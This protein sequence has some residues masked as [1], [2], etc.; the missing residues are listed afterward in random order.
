[1]RIL[2]TGAAGFIGSHMSLRL[3]Q[4]G[5]DVRGLDNF[6]S[7]YDPSLKHKN[8]KML[9][10]SG[11][12]IHRLD[13]AQDPLEGVLE[14]V[15]V[16]I[17]LAAQPGNDAST[18]YFS[19]TKNNFHAAVALTESIKA[20]ENKPKLIHISTSSVYGLNAKGDETTL[21]APVSPYGVTKV[22][23]ETAVLSAMRRKELEAVVLRLFSVYGERERPDKLFPRLFSA[24]KHGTE[25]PLF[26]GSRTHQR[27][28]SYVGDIVE[29]ILLAVKNFEKAKGEVFNIGTNLC[30]TTG[31]AIDLAQAISGK[32]LKIKN[33]PPRPG[34]QAATHAQIAKATT[35]LG[36]N[37][38]VTLRE[39]LE[40]VNA[41]A[42][43]EL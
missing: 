38:K 1:M 8:A 2:V 43:K 39:G 33:L 17:N 11:I 22:A 29:G 34:D 5:Y 7:Y 13:L 40:R 24:L 25:F 28:Y 23:A 12:L 20:L 16:V 27:S 36:Y 10:K 4:E 30:F 6:D 31:E 32:T 41:W 3:K 35:L 15:E 21:P 9:E 19:Y 14:G 37:P 26:E 18:T 42:Q